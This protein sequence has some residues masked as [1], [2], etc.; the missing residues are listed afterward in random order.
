MCHIHH[1]P[2]PPLFHFFL[3]HSHHFLFISAMP[4]KDV[5]EFLESKNLVHLSPSLAKLK[6]FD[7]TALF[8]IDAALLRQHDWNP[9][10][11]VLLLQ[12]IGVEDTPIQSNSG[13][14]PRRDF[15]KIEPRTRGSVKRA[16]GAAMPNSRQE[17][18]AALQDD[19]YA[20]SS[21]PSQQ[22][23]FVTWSKL[24][25][26]WGLQPIPI[27]RQVLL[28]I[29]A[30]M[31]HAGYRSPTNYFYKAAQI[32][33]E[34]LEEDLPPHLHSLMQKILRSIKRGQGPTPFKDSFE[35]ELF[36]I[37]L[38]RTPGTVRTGHW[39]TDTFAARDITLIACWWMLRGMEA[40]AAKIQHVWFHEING[41]NLLISLYQ[42][43]RMTQPDSAWA[44]DTHAYA[45]RENQ[46]HYAHTMPSN[47]IP[48]DYTISS[49]TI[50]RSNYHLYPPT[51]ANSPPRATSWR[52]S[53]LPSP[54]Q[55]HPIALTDTPLTRP[56]PHGEPLPRF[57]EHVCRVSGAQFLSRLGY[58]LEAIQLIGRWGSDAVKRYIQE[59]P[60][61]A[62]PNHIIAPQSTDRPDIQQLVRTELERLCN[63]WWILNQHSNTA[64]IPAV[65]E[66]A[67]N[68]RW[69]TLC[70]WHYGSAIYQKTFTRPTENLCRKC[71]KEVEEDDNGTSS[72][73][74]LT[75]RLQQPA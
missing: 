48:S 34:T 30:S 2:S 73:D 40:A 54:S 72:E 49:N 55:T 64:H 6:I 74:E 20:N 33:R 56:G 60:L 15:P 21:K 41:P 22:S 24:A 61:A 36:N 45:G 5:L 10:D 71:F 17:S 25:T 38:T 43:R 3:F 67:Q 32:H 31:K 19:F 23:L 9:T 8:D 75:W 1:P 52:S 65:P 16:I 42:Y 53:P 58:S 50:T 29:G 63:S 46:T 7:R 44:A 57:G 66:T 12:A 59:A 18:I 37:Q 70:G 13:P 14:T 51:M 4:F 35:L 28:S 62:T 69:R 47:D 11:I 39:F 27:T 26:A 68:T